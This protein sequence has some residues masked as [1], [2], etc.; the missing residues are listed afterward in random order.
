MTFNPTDNIKC[1]EIDTNPDT[2]LEN[3][4]RFIAT[5]TLPPTTVNLGVTS[6]ERTQ[7]PVSIIDDDSKNNEPQ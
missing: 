1:I 7:A 4:E 6:G 3:T 5:L 2:I